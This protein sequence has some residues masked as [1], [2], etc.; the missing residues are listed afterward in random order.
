MNGILENAQDK[1]SSGVKLFLLIIV[2]G[3]IFSSIYFALR[4]VSPVTS[5]GI[6]SLDM[7]EVDVILAY[8]RKPDC[9]EQKDPDHK[10][11]KFNGSNEACNNL[12]YLTKVGDEFE[13]SMICS[14]NYWAFNN[15]DDWTAEPGLIARLG[16]PSHT[17][18][19]SDGTTKIVSFQRYNVAFEFES[20]KVINTCVTRA[21]PVKYTDEYKR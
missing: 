21:L 18:I 5:L 9:S 10:I 8:G 2:L 20:G 15:I 14:S 1:K 17:S 7:K 4:Y 6:V 11:I 19:N 3:I 16:S 13:V 12:V